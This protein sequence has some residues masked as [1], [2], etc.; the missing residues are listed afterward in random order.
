MPIAHAHVV[1]HGDG[2]IGFLLLGRHRDGRHKGDGRV[3]APL[4]PFAEDLG[5]PID[6]LRGIETGLG[7]EVGAGLVAQTTRRPRP[8]R[9][10]G[11]GRPVKPETIDVQNADVL[12]HV[13]GPPLPKVG[14]GEAQPS[15]IRLSFSTIV[16]GLDRPPVHFAGQ[17]P[18]R[19]LGQLLKALHEDA[20][21]L[22]APNQGLELPWV[23][24]LVHRDHLRIKEH[25]MSGPAGIDRPHLRA[26]V[27]NQVGVLLDRQAVKGFDLTFAIIG[28]RHRADAARKQP[29]DSLIQRHVL[30][31]LGVRAHLRSVGHLAG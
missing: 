1:D 10:L 11:E 16:D 30:R 23:N 21:L 26:H 15:R 25:A 12:D 5:T 29:A 17:V 4:D 27:S 19:N 31:Q 2:Q 14:A 7:L 22:R 24:V 18:V 6:L 3:V 28:V 9:T 20:S 13:L 8:A